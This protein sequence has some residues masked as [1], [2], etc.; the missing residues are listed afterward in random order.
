MQLIREYSD[1]VKYIT[2]S[3]DSKDGKSLYI[4]GIFL[5]SEVKNRNGR[6]YRK[7]AMENEVNRYINEKVNKHTAYGELDHPATPTVN[8]KN[9]SHIITELRQDGNVW[10]GKAKILDTPMGQIARGIV[11]SGGT[12]G[13]SSRGLGETRVIEGITY[14]E[15]FM[16]MTAADIVSDP[17]APGAFVSGI[18]ENKEWVMVDGVWTDKECE[19]SKKLIREASQ[20]EIE[21]I[22][23]KIFS[24]F[25]NNL[26]NYK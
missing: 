12:L 2:E 5:V 19:Q 13:V 10:Y 20:K 16:L 18:M 7:S 1:D 22:S 9:A 21:E 15:N 14:V 11:N 8:L 4:E 6:I 17:S 25:I 26:K 24:N 3:S 23:L